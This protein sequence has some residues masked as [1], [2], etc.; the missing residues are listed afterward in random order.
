[1]DFSLL[2]LDA[3]HT[4]QLASSQQLLWTLVQNS[5]VS[6]S[7]QQWEFINRSKLW[8]EKISW[9][10]LAGNQGLIDG[11][12]DWLIDWLIDLLNNDWLIDDWWI[13]WLIDWSINWL[14]DWL[15]DWLVD[16]LIDWLIDWLVDWL[17]EPWF[18]HWFIHWVTIF[19][20]IDMSSRSSPK[21]LALSVSSS[22]TRCDTT[23]R[24]VISSLASN[25][26][27][28]KQEVSHDSH[29]PIITTEW[30]HPCGLGVRL[31]T[32]MMGSH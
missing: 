14:I 3:P 22:F 9:K 19:L 26:A 25:S 11:L 28:S 12:I 6:I 30:L 13:D 31:Y 1:M 24:W 7:E 17:I 21:L 29:M 2:F 8:R 16:W 4:H 18:N 32:S 10:M 20:T 15:I 27:Y 5:D 23:S